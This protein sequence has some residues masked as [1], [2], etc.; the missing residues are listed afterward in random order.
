MHM[1]TRVHIQVCVLP[2]ESHDFRHWESWEGSGNVRNSCDSDY[3]TSVAPHCN[4][5]LLCCFH[6]G[7]ELLSLVSSTSI[8]LN[9][10][11]IVWRSPKG[12]SR[13][14]ALRFATSKLISKCNFSFV[15]NIVTWCI[16]DIA[17]PRWNNI[18]YQN[19]VNIVLPVWASSELSGL[20]FSLLYAFDDDCKR[21]ALLVTFLR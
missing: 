5:L 13:L 10:D 19:G 9:P 21:H 7:K 3:V 14:C 2:V 17:S 20:K 8:P 15:F 16:L 11:Q 12:L 18:S 1:G 4:F 6:I